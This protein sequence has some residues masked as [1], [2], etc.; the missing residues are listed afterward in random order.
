MVDR[1][2]GPNGSEGCLEIA[3]LR[4]LSGG[5]STMRKMEPFFGGIRWTGR[6]DAS[7]RPAFDAG[8][9]VVS[10]R[11]VNVVLVAVVITVGAGPSA[12]IIEW[13]SAS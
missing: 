7:S 11:S 10:Q 4:S 3:R 1:V 12:R 5:T 8:I 9:C 13:P 2:R 6:S